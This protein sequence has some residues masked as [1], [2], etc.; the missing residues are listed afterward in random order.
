LQPENELPDQVRQPPVPQTTL[1][2][3]PPS[4][5]TQL[6]NKVTD[7]ENRRAKETGLAAPAKATTTKNASS[8]QSKGACSNAAK[9]VKNRTEGT[10]GK[11]KGKLEH[12][13]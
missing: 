7:F 6:K 3:K 8:R 13:H 12:V 1:V 4:F 9:A 11:G 10:R 2:A 5:A